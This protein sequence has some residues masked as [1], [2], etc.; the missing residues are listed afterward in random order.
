MNAVETSGAF[1]WAMPHTLFDHV[2]MAADCCAA[3]TNAVA[4]EDQQW[5]Q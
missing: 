4:K 1:V 5:L 3:Q 2:H